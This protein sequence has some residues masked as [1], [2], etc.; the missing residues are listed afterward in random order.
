MIQTMM[1]GFQTPGGITGRPIEGE[2]RM[3][4]EP[5]KILH[6]DGDYRLMLFVI[7]DGCTIKS[8]VPLN[9]GVDMLKRDTFDLILSEP[10]QRAYLDPRW[11]GGQAS[12]GAPPADLDAFLGGAPFGEGPA[13]FRETGSV[14]RGGMARI[15]DSVS[16]PAPAAVT[17]GAAIAAKKEGL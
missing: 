11:S 12:P 3:G 7:M 16:S 4:G 17:E 1:S 10:H 13:F 2:V 15:D 6:I 8:R 9:K 14:P 5:I